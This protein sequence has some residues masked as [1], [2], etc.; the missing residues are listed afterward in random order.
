MLASVVNFFNPSL[1]VIGGGVA[2]AGDQLLA[3]IRETVYRRSLPLATRELVVKR[4]ALGDRAGVVGAAAI[5]TD[6]LFRPSHL[7]QWLGVGTPNGG[8]V[9]AAPH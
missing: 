7:T 6:E 2:G 4:S 1:V 5:V 9:V 3:T 8:H